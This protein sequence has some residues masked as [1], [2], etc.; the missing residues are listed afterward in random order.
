MG[1][2]L[3]PILRARSFRTTICV[4]RHTFRSR[5]PKSTDLSF[6]FLQFRSRSDYDR[7]PLVLTRVTFIRPQR[8]SDV[9]SFDAWIIKHYHRCKASVKRISNHCLQHTK[10]R[11]WTGLKSFGTHRRFLANELTSLQQPYN[12]AQLNF[13][14]CWMLSFSATRLLR[15]FSPDI[16]ENSSQGALIIKT[17]ESRPE[18]NQSYYRINTTLKTHQNPIKTPSKPIKIIKHQQ[19]PSKSIKIHQNPPKSIKSHHKLV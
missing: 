14:H 3:S 11:Q 6:H 10:M 4:A 8:S 15:D 5:R 2:T 19:N 16:Y 13:Q 7:S 17:V 18:A 12:R 9:P 1:L